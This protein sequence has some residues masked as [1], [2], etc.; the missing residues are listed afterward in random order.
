MAVALRLRGPLEEAALRAALEDVLVRH[1]AT[2]ASETAATGPAWTSAAVAE[3]DL[4]AALRAETVRRE[5]ADGSEPPHR[6]SL[7]RTDADE[8]VLLAVVRRDAA[9]GWSPDRL[10][11][12]LGTAYRAR[13]DGH[14]PEWPGRQAQDGPSSRDE[15]IRLS[16]HIDFWRQE[17]AGLPGQLELPTDL[18]RPAVLSHAG[19]VV[20]HPL[21]V[22]VREGLPA[23]AED[24]GTTPFMVVQAA[25]AALLTRLGAGTDVPIGAAARPATTTGPTDASGSGHAHART[26]GFGFGSGD[27]LV[28]LR[29]DTTGNPTFRRLLDRVRQTDLAAFAHQDAPFG[30]VVEAV[31]GPARTR[32]EHPLFQVFLDVPAGP[33]LDFGIAGGIAGDIDIDFGAVTVE[34]EPVDAVATRP[35][36]AF[37]VREQREAPGTAAGLSLRLDYATDLFDRAGAEALTARLARVLGAAVSDPDQRIADLD[38]LDPEERER[39]L[40]TWNETSR[41]AR[42]PGSLQEAFAAQARRTPEAVAVSA[43]SRAL[44]YAQL[45]ARAN[46]LAHRLIGHGVGPGTCVAILQQRSVDLV[47]SILA[48]VKAGGTYVPLHTGYSPAWMELA[49]RETGSTVILT[50]RAMGR[51]AFDHPAV[52]VVVDDH[53]EPFGTE[54]ETDPA[55]PGLPEQ[56]AY[57]MYT[58]GSTGVPKGV[59]ITHGDVLD[60]AADECWH[61]DAGPCS[62]ERVLLHSPYAF[63]P[64][65]FEV[66]APLLNGHQIV[67]A[68][69]GDL[70]TRE[71]EKVLVEGR[72]TGA[73][74]TAGLFRLMAE[75]APHAF[76]GLREVWTGGD[77]VSPTAVQRVL[78]ACPDTTVTAI[79]GPTEITLC[80]TKYRM[81]HPHR[82]EETVVMGAPMDNT[83]AYVLD[84]HLNPVPPGVPGELYI[85]GS[86][87]ARG[88]VDRAPL[89][90]ERFVADPFGPAGERM[91]RTGDLVRWTPEGNLLFI[92]RADGQVKIR[93]FRVE[94]G[95]V[96]AALV[97]HP[98]LAQATVGVRPDPLGDKRL[99]AWVVPADGE[100][101]RVDALR[102]HVAGL[103]PAYMVPTF[104]VVPALPLTPNAKVDRNALPD[105]DFTPRTDSRP[106]RTAHE[107]VLCRLA[108]DILCL[109]QVGPDDDFFALGGH[110]L[111]ATRLVNRIRTAL[112]R[113]LGIETL[114]AAPTMAALAEHIGSP[115]T[116]ARTALSPRDG[117]GD[118]PLSAAQHRLWFLDRLD[119]ASPA[120]NIPL[121]VRLSGPLDVP[122]LR[123][124]LDDVVERHESLRTVVRETGGEPVQR[125]LRADAVPCVL[126]DVL[127]IDPADAGAAAERAAR[128]PFDLVTD[129][130]I[131]ATL[132]RTAPQE[133][134]LVIALHHLAG[135]GWSLIPLCEDLGT[136]YAARITGA[137]PGWE[138]LRVQYADYTAW[139][140]RLLGDES[141]PDSVAGR[142]LAFWRTALDGIPQQLNLPGE[143]APATAGPATDEARLHEHRFDGPLHARLVTLAQENRATLFMVVQAALAAVLTKLGA[144]TDIPLGAPVSGRADESLDPLVGFFV[145]TLVL[146]TDTSGDPTF[147]E[148]LGRVRT[149]DLAAYAHQD[150]PFD[151]VVHQLDPDRADGRTPLFQVALAFDNIT[152]LGLSLPGL[153]AEGHVVATGRPKCDLWLGIGETH[154][155]QGT[156]AGMSLV[157][158]YAA[159]RL[160]AGTVTGLV[161]RL[162]RL[163]RAAVDTP[164]RPLSRIEVLAADERA[165]LLATGDGTRTGL[166]S[167]TVVDLFEARAAE[168]P[169]A[170][171]VVAEDAELSY[172][173]LNRRANRLAHLLIARGL[174]PEDVVAMCLTR[175]AEQ[176][177]TLLAIWKAGA[178][179]LPLDP[180]Y[181]AAR[182][183]YMLGDTRPA[184]LVVDEATAQLGEGGEVPVLRLGSADTAAHPAT[185]PTPAE[186]RAPLHAD[187]AAY[188]IYTSGSTGRPKGVV[189]SHRG[190][191]NTAAAA[192][193]HL[194][195]TPDSRVLQ[196]ASLNFDA[197]VWDIAATLTAGAALVLG[198]RDRAELGLPFAEFLTRNRV[199]HATLSPSLLSSLPADAESGGAGEMTVAV[200]GEACPADIAARWAPGRRML[201]AYGPTETTVCAT[202]SDPLTGTGTPPIGRPIQNARVYVL[203]AHLAP[204][205][206]GVVG[207]VYVAGAGVARGYL[208]RPGLTAERFVAD[209]FGEPGTRMYR[210]GDLAR[211]SGSGDLLFAGRVDHQVKIRGYR[212]ELG[213]I[214]DRLNQHPAVSDSFVKLREDGSGEP[215]L[216]AYVLV[217]E[218]GTGPGT[219]TVDPDELRAL[220]AAALPEYMV[221]TAYVSLRA[222]PLSP[223]GK[224]DERALPAPAP[225]RPAVGHAPRTPREEVLCRLF[226]EFLDRDD[227]GVDESFFAL[228]GHSLMATR[229]VGR[230]R[231]ELKV[232][233][234]MR[235]LFAHPTVAGLAEQLEG[236]KAAAPRPRSRRAAGGRP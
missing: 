131:R 4:P 176:I 32:S 144:G 50:D 182:T 6:A 90:A 202:V 211:W 23:L 105:P 112:D 34:A 183:A 232:E 124:A 86:G 231:S 216:V 223:N 169:Q 12:D 235:T 113:D 133:H 142:Q 37:H 70:D 110:S 150:V 78:D 180:A 146:R 68:P 206:V 53:D 60:L 173:E 164:D 65:T 49:V 76:A 24:T 122:A 151:R 157:A 141:D 189:V 147:R 119:G 143:P 195:I 54:T 194:G 109:P 175:S 87:L 136:A 172:A 224:L 120:Y 214:A 219:G 85:A 132:F 186:R 58:S 3:A 13:L 26:H 39:I 2:G 125:I 17:L 40:Y 168:R 193:H 221:P 74:I 139:Q 66:W 200:A 89:T 43:G 48:I 80:C 20:E 29:T 159:A 104:V 140:R 61:P 126:G 199:T 44:T 100:D 93:G 220:A 88:Y 204:V 205:P 153:H 127:D 1:G 149:A 130:P 192:V 95:E 210:T 19:D 184:L 52:V 165:A 188:V 225:D 38:V 62:A 233:L 158:E 190:I 198:P 230:I 138:Q 46:R 177:V 101:V 212:I 134:L 42:L 41:P 81:K 7:F 217:P 77:V 103:L 36:L 56:L 73:L 209:P 196:F 111:L 167:G 63:D 15:D 174:G 229:L 171:A 5:P 69:A 92:G 121:A 162:E 75:E 35:D 72:V 118:E 27:D 55:V 201:N 163:L 98:H 83:R 10:V 187:H 18:K 71:L 226:G 67:V 123:A 207:E 47:V 45:D 114:F 64:S 14:A 28:V 228:G 31:G 137:R 213:E 25:L 152:G 11:A 21:P 59:A 91:Y 106:A 82:V 8:H 107:E 197:S 179:Y 170:T 57:V 154:D 160:D 102:E 22:E 117:R 128:A 16:R 97:R 227:V 191:P 166:P 94:P 222:W 208:G 30:Q 203:D 84:E 156:A 99:V 218:S 33:V 155:E 129:L 181:P 79:Y 234:S 108:A 148:L 96:E 185:D 51:P 215:R 116:E 115:A 9:H 135:D 145:N 178:A 236:A 161:E